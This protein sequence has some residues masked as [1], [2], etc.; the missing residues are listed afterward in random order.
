[1]HQNVLAARAIARGSHSPRRS[2]RQGLRSRAGAPGRSRRRV[3]GLDDTIWSA[4]IPPSAVVMYGKWCKAAM[5]RGSA[6]GARTTQ[7]F[8]Q[9]RAM[10]PT[11]PSSARNSCS[12]S[13]ATT[14]R[15]R[16]TETRSSLPSGRS[17]TAPARCP[18]ASRTAIP[19]HRGWF[20][21]QRG[22]SP[23]RPGPERAEARR[24]RPPRP[25]QHPEVASTAGH[26]S[27]LLPYAV[28]FALTVQRISGRG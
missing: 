13:H 25:Q 2:S 28:T 20:R 17:R 3:V 1:M 21:R 6:H 22:A 7:G 11:S 8:T 4:V 16:A 14:S 24:Q 19:A 12:T 26:T 27:P 23:R 5:G 9:R 10:P 18:P 15:R